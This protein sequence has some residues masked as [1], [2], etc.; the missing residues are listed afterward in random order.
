VAQDGRIPHA[1]LNRQFL[2]GQLD[3]LTW[4]ILNHSVW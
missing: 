3:R 1:G 2:V 4:R